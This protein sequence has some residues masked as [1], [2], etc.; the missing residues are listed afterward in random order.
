MDPRWLWLVVPLLQFLQQYLKVE[1]WFFTPVWGVLA[2]FFARYAWG[3]GLSPGSLYAAAYLAVVWGLGFVYGFERSPYAASVTAAVWNGVYL[4]LFVLAREFSRFAALGLKRGEWW[5]WLVSV[6]YA[7][8][9]SW[10]RPSPQW[11]GTDLLPS[12]AVS[13]ASSFLQ[14]RYG[15]FVSI[16]LAL[17]YGVVPYVVP[18]ALKM[19]WVLYGLVH[20]LFLLAVYLDA[21][22]API[23]RGEVVAVLSIVMLVAF[24]VGAFGVRPYVIASGSMAPVYNIGDVVFVVPV[25]E[26]SVGDVVLFRAD[27]GYVLHRIIDKYRGEDGRWYYRTKGDA[28]ESPDPKPVPQ[29]NLVGKAILKIPYAGWIVLWARDPVNGWPYLT[30]LLLT[31]AFLEV[32]VKKLIDR[33]RRSVSRR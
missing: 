10:L 29:D 4:T 17:A 22:P 33:S 18:V 31:A 8:N 12:L 9:D 5:V 19:P 11:V 21:S 1:A 20:A 26:A 23:S 27:I 6:A 16:P 24:A 25:K 13:A 14:V 30:T 3:G 32:A 28:N 2:L 15:V 7:F